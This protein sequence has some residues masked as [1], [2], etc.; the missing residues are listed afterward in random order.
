[1]NITTILYDGLREL[2]A[3]VADADDDE[4]AAPVIELRRLLQLADAIL[5]S[6]P[7]YAGTLPGSLKNLLDWTIPNGDLYAKPVAWLNVAAPGRGAGALATLRVVLDFATAEIISDACRSIFVGRDALGDDG[8]VSSEETREQ[9]N[10]VLRS[11]AAHVAA[12]A[13]EVAVT[14]GR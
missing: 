8:L 2:P 14:S 9:I 10:D 5:I 12:R 13:E 3:F 6:T 4:L 11:I 7:E 1:V